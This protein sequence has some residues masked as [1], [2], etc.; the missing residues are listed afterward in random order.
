[1]REWAKLLEGS[2]KD[3]GGGGGGGG[4]GGSMEDQDFEFMLKV[5]R[6]IQSEQ[7]I[8]ARTRAIEQLR[9]STIPRQRPRLQ[10]RLP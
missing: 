6:M 3:G 2:Q 5:M 9:R 1:M 4:S 8:R 7:D 10:P